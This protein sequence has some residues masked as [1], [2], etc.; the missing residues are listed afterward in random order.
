MSEPCIV[1]GENLIL[2][3]S[4]EEERMQRIRAK[5]LRRIDEWMIAMRGTS[6][7]DNP[8]ER[9]KIEEILREELQ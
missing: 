7:P 9:A 1:H 3:A 8:A 4:C 2:C 5:V 6:W